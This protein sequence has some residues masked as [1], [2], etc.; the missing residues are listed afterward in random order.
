MEWIK[1][2]N[3]RAEDLLR[4]GIHIHQQPT[5]TGVS[6]G[7]HSTVSSAVVGA[8]GLIGMQPAV[9]SAVTGAWISVTWSLQG[10]SN[11]AGAGTGIIN[12]QSSTGIMSP[13]LAWSSTLASGANHY[14][15]SPFPAQLWA[16]QGVSTLS[17]T[18]P[19]LP[20]HLWLPYQQ[21][22][23]T[24]PNQLIAGIGSPGMGA[25]GSARPGMV[26]GSR[27]VP[28]TLL[29]QSLLHQDWF[30]SDRSTESKGKRAE[31][32][33]HPDFYLSHDKK[34]DDICYQEL[35]FGMVSVAE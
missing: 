9:S 21:T 33:L 13:S 16:T 15:V 28:P 22:S 3:D 14:G 31:H 12:P 4:Q 24:L 2:S 8:G 20:N 11:M 26:L 29:P 35:L 25:V 7:V 1:L 34:Y 19:G 23:T 32:W 27:I 5:V 6:V 30:S 18:A 10:Q 17:N